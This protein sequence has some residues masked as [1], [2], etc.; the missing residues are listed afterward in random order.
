MLVGTAV[1]GQC[2]PT[3]TGCSRLRF[4]ARVMVGKVIYNTEL[5]QLPAPSTSP[6]AE[7]PARGFRDLHHVRD[8]RS[9]MCAGQLHTQ[10]VLHEQTSGPMCLTLDI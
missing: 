10:K 5:S 9:Q 4:G 8:E 7:C 2:C 3:G 6:S 1:H